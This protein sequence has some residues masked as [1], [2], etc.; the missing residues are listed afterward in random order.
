MVPIK[1]LH[2]VDARAVGSARSVW[3][4]LLL[5]GVMFSFASALYPLS[6]A[7]RPLF[8]SL[9]TIARATAITA[10]GTAYL[11]GLEG[12]ILG[13][14]VATSALW[15]ITCVMLDLVML[16]TLPPRLSLPEYLSRDGLVYLMIPPIVLGLAYQRIRTEGSSP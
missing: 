12:R 3:L 8:E 6:V 14:A 4:G 16:M 10:F 7:D 15:T 11:R 5:W 1:A 9:A 13:R 2:D